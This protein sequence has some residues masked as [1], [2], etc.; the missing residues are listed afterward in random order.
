MNYKKLSVYLLFTFMFVMPF[1]AA[2]NLNDAIPTDGWMSKITE[3]LNLGT[4]W[5]QVIAALCII[6]IIYA[7]LYDILSFTAFESEWVKHGIALA[8]AVVTALSNFP[9]IAA[10]W[11]L[12]IIGGAT[13]FGV[14]A[15]IIVAI[16]F[17]VGASFFTSKL[18]MMRGRMSAKADLAKAIRGRARIVAGERTLGSVGKESIDEGRSTK[19]EF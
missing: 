1:V 7:A 2:F 18:K 9:L 15:I 13:I 12:Q 17:F 19:D 4:N 11:M 6:F 14:G 5:A 3:A 8:I 10:I 16:A